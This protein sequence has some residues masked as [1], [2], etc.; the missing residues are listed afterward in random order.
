MAASA[1]LGEMV[2]LIAT[3]GV[4]FTYSASIPDKPAIQKVDFTINSPRIE[5]AIVMMTN[6]ASIAILGRSVEQ[7]SVEHVEFSCNAH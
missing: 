5:G 4:L 2:D 1:R 3:T 7:T 6:V